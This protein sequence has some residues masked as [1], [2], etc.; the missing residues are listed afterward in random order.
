MDVLYYVP[1]FRDGLDFHL[2][3]KIVNC[4]SPEKPGWDGLMQNGKNMAPCQITCHFSLAEDLNR[5]NKKPIE[6]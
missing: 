2:R 3:T 6:R 1:G 4:D 5:E